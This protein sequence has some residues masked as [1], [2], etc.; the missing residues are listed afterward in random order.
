MPWLTVDRGDPDVVILDVIGMPPRE[1]T[2]AWHADRTLAPAA[3]AFVE[4][5]QE[6]AAGLWTASGY[7]RRVTKSGRA[8]RAADR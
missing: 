5:V 4:V 6:V 8:K 2:I 7:A 3:R 1:I